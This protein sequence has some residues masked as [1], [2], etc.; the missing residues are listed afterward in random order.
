ML[1]SRILRAAEDVLK[2]Y[3]E[4]KV[5]ELLQQAMQCASRQLPAGQFTNAAQQ[6]SKGGEKLRDQSRLRLYPQ[7]MAEYLRESGY[8]P[9]LP[10][11]IGRFL[12]AGFRGDPS[13]IPQTPEVQGVYNAFNIAMSDLNSLV[14]TLR[15]LDTEPLTI[16]EGHL[17]IDFVVP[18]VVV[19]NDTRQLLHLQET[20]CDLVE[21]LNEYV[22]ADELSPK[23]V[24]TSTTDPVIAIALYANTAYAVVRLFAEMLKAAKTAVDLYRSVKLL[25]AQSATQEAAK[26]LLANI[27]AAVHAQ[28][29]K[30]VREQLEM[31]VTK[32]DD[33]RKNELTAAVIKRIEVLVPKV[34]EGVSIGISVESVPAVAST[35]VPEL[36]AG[37]PSLAQAVADTRR[38]ETETR[39]AITAAGGA[40]SLRLTHD[41]KEPGRG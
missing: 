1:A 41:S 25:Q 17:S 38:L 10:E 8:G 16:P 40:A 13:T 12:T 31:L 22:G 5:S 29:E 9:A 36:S 33:G 26:S 11:N 27:E 21:H 20:F 19:D 3:Q 37:H 23:L 15:K 18:R 39:N 14:S 32:L 7:Q 28:V 35:V 30:A 24:Y 34:A 4:L 2:D 6:V